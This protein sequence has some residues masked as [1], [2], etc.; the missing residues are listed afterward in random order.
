M[1]NQRRLPRPD[2]RMRARQR[3][4][5]GAE[6]DAVLGLRA[7]RRADKTIIVFFRQRGVHRNGRIV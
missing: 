7:V 4:E 3:A 2:G 1:G 6:I 5:V